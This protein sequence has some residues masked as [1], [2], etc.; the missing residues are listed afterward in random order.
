MTSKNQYSGAEGRPRLIQALRAQTVVRHEL[1]VAEA[2]ADVG[3]L[4]PVKAGD[5]LV[6]EGDTGS[7]FFFVLEGAFAILVKRNRVGE[8]SYGDHI[9]EIAALDPGQ[10]RSAT[11]TAIEPSVV[12]RV[13]GE[14]FRDLARTHPELMEAVALE[15]NKRLAQ[16]NDRECA[17][18]ESPQIVAISAKEALPVVREIEGLLRDDAFRFRPWDQG[19]VFGIS[20]YP[21]PSL[22]EA[23]KGADF[24]LVLAT[25]EDKVRTRG[26][27]R[28]V[29]R[30]NVTFEM[31]M[32]I[33]ILGLD[34]VI[35]VTP[36]AHTDLSSD[37]NGVTVLRYRTDREL[38]EA[39]RPIVN[40][41]RKHIALRGAIT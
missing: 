11:V 30:D 26:K 21:V 12:W 5:S 8:R 14:T 24:A 23:L 28:P 37:M 17:R 27:T 6:H 38:D 19:G 40:D 36:A 3:D 35:V 34:R 31:G 15:A 9:G 1:T 2:L 20:S 13:P 10:K 32:A 25:P 29:P 41:L 4:L 18:N 16:R 33:G 7:D 22:V 39:L